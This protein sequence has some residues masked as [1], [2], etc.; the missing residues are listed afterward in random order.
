[1]TSWFQNVLPTKNQPQVQAPAS[2]QTPASPQA[3]QSAQ[4]P[5][6]QK[7][8]P[9][10]QAATPSQGDS[11]LRSA[12]P[13][14]T[15]SAVPSDTKP[16]KNATAQ[17]PLEGVS[18]PNRERSGTKLRPSRITIPNR[19]VEVVGARRGQSFAGIC[20]ERFNGCTPALLNTIVELNPGIKDHDH[21]EA[22]QRVFL[23]VIDSRPKQSN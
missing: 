15:K 13:S 23:P 5:I 4:T 9:P 16:A 22:G 11:S 6:A 21:L 17:A 12:V 10:A 14:E 19:G 18:K 3:D 1:V 2:P 20:V 7:D 8:E